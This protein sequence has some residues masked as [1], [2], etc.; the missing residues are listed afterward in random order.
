[1]NSVAERRFVTRSGTGV[2]C[3]RVTGDPGF[4]VEKVTEPSYG[5]DWMAQCST[6]EAVF[7]DDMLLSQGMSVG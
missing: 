4:E 7:I 6:G 1:V 3:E 2:H 5:D